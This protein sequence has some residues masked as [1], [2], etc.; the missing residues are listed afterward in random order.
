MPGSG[1]GS[2]EARAAA[3]R[4]RDEHTRRASPAPVAARRGARI[5]LPVV[6]PLSFLSFEP[7]VLELKKQNNVFE[8]I[9][10]VSLDT[11]PITL[12]GAGPAER[13]V[14]QGVS[15]NLFP[16]LGVAPALGRW[17]EPTDVQRSQDPR[18]ESPLVLSYGIWQRR[19]SGNPD[20]LGKTLSLEG[21]KPSPVV[22]IMPPVFF[23]YQPHDVDVWYSFDPESSLWSK[24]LDHALSCPRPPETGVF[25]AQ[26]Q[27]EMEIIAASL[28]KQYPA[29][30][31]D[32]SLQIRDLRAALA[33]GTT[34]I[35]PLL[36][37]VGFVLLIACANVANLLLARMAAR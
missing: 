10:L 6:F 4:A 30:N 25:L 26:A 5:E 27:A 22:G 2:F 35:Y 1:G 13:V 37:A 14:Q 7:L 8:D 31:R 16:L 17:I 29:T 24:R 36:G 3:A 23:I 15:P 18:G 12:R 33:G 19:F 32:T 34:L 11:Y 9:G 21:G 20:I 28:A